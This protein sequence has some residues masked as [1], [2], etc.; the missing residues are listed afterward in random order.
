VKIIGLVARIF[1]GL[2]FLVFGLNGFLHFLTLP[3]EDGLASQFM[4]A[5]FLSHYLSVVYFLELAGGLLL[6]VNRLVPLA[7]VVLGPIVVNILFFHA[8]MAPQ[9]I[10]LALGTTALFLLAVW[11]NR[12]YFEPVF[13]LVP[14]EL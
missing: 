5:L 8:L 3:H 13:T 12:H 14:E 6:L 9:G 11:S 10:P 4:G 2:I 1:L 7:L